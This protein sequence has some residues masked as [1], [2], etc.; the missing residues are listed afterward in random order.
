VTPE[1]VQADYHLTPIPSPD[2][3]DPRLDPHTEPAYARSFATL[4]G[5]RRVTPV[6]GPVGDRSDDPDRERARP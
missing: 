5:S 1:R 3:P 2:E 4:A 6:V